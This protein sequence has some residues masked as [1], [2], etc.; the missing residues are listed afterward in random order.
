MMN[1]QQQQA[2]T[3]AIAKVLKARFPNLSVEETLKL[4][5]EI[6][7]EVHTILYPTSPV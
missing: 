5:H 3:V 4:S 2:V 1:I 6:A 7:F